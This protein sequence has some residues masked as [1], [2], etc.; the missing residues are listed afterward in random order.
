MSKNRRTPSTIVT[1]FAIAL[2]LSSASATAQSR[3]VQTYTV[4]DAVSL[5]ENIGPNRTVVLKKGDYLL[6]TAYG[7]ET[8]YVSWYEGEDGQ[9]LELSD[10]ENVT[11]RG[12][13]GARI[14]CDA[15]GASVISLYSSRNVTFDN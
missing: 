1:L 14:L 2:V 4:T 5:L 11:I 12:A 10:L 15:A 13:E 8:D 9:E 6:S 3:Q 7:I